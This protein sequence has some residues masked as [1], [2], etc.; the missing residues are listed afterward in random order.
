MV[1]DYTL[2]FYQFTSR[3]DLNESEDQLIARYVGELKQSVK[4]KI[5]LHT[6]FDLFDAIQM[7]EDIEQAASTSHFA[8]TLTGS[9]FKE[10]HNYGQFISNKDNTDK[11]PLLD[12]N[13]ETPCSSRICWKSELDKV[14]SLPRCGA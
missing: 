10:A 9:N 6:I 11:G 13:H 14:L 7:V 4:E 3:N 5:P 1:E 12:T 2:E 8:F